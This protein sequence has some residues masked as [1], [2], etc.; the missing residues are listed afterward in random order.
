MMMEGLL[1]GILVF[2]GWVFSVLLVEKYRDLIYALMGFMFG[3]MAYYSP[4][5]NSSETHNI[6]PIVMFA[7]GVY[8]TALAFMAVIQKR[9]L[10]R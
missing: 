9:S 8:L 2:A 7:V 3:V 4:V 6:L 1:I 10:T 5:L